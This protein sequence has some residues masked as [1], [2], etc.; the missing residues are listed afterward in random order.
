MIPHSAFPSRALRLPSR[1]TACLYVSPSRVCLWLSHTQTR[2]LHTAH[3][4]P[5]TLTPSHGLTHTHRH[6]ARAGPPTRPPT[7]PYTHIMSNVM[8]LSTGAICSTG[9][10]TLYDTDSNS[11]RES[12]GVSPRS[13]NVIITSAPRDRAVPSK[14]FETAKDKCI[15]T[16]LFFFSNL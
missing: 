7:V 5:P 16:G 6:S 15:K 1:L 11:P 2:S 4:D 13:D 3:A 14:T 12:H 8:N 9:W 10:L